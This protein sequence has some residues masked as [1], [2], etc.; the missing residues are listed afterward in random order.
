MQNFVIF[1]HRAPSLLGFNV[2]PI[3]ITKRPDS[4]AITLICVFM[5]LAYNIFNI[6]RRHSIPH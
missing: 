5:V 1:L 4:D 6:F 3:V 2:K